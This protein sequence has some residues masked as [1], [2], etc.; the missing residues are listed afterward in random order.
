MD[1]RELDHLK[2]VVN[3]L[4]NEE[5]KHYEEEPDDDHVFVSVLVLDEFVKRQS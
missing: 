2:I 5:R 1:K 3:Y 4:Y